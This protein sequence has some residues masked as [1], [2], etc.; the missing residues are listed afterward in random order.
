MAMLGGGAGG[1]AWCWAPCMHGICIPYRAVLGSPMIADRLVWA[2][3]GSL[4]SLERPLRWQELTTRLCL[5]I[6][7]L[8]DSNSRAIIDMIDDLTRHHLLT[9]ANLTPPA[10]SVSFPKWVRFIPLRFSIC[11]GNRSRNW[12]VEPPKECRN[13]SA[14][15][16][17]KQHIVCAE[18]D[19]IGLLRPAEPRDPRR[20]ICKI[21]RPRP[22]FSFFVQA[23]C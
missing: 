13:R 17:A 19:Q 15:R 16:E 5:G 21:L 3:G 10:A 9:A 2:G 22:D 4:G 6:G 8:P 11:I 14:H 18:A 23:P 12:W 20:R 7:T 1:G